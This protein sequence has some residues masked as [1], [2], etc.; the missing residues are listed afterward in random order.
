MSTGGQ[1]WPP[2]NFPPAG[3]LLYSSDIFYGGAVLLAIPGPEA[4]SFDHK[5]PTSG[6]RKCCYLKR[7]RGTS[8]FQGNTPCRGVPLPVEP[9]HTEPADD[10]WFGLV[11]DVEPQLTEVVMGKFGSLQVRG[12]LSGT[13][14]LNAPSRSANH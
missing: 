8:S 13:L 4:H 9:K 6:F 11:I 2:A 5:H 1:W 3:I 7:R 14:N 10:G 12:T